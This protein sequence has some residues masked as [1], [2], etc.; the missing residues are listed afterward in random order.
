MEKIRVN[1]WAKLNLSL[2]L[3]PKKGDRGYF[4][5]KFINTQ[6]TLHDSVILCKTKAPGIKLNIYNEEEA[7]E[8]KKNLAFKAAFL[9]MQTFNLPGGIQISIK[10]NIPIRAGLGGG[11]ADAGAVINGLGKLFSIQIS[12]KDKS[13][14]AGRLGMDV[15]YCV[16]GGLCRVEGIGE[17]VEPIPFKLPDLHILIATPIV[18]KP[19]T[20]W[21]Y[22]LIEKK[23]IGKNIEKYNKLIEAIKEE[24]ARAIAENLHNDFEIHVG[25]YFPVIHDLKKIMLR[26][27]AWGAQLAGSGLS[28]FGIFPDDT[29][30]QNA[31]SIL[32]KQ[33]I[34]CI[35][36]KPVNFPS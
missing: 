11:S 3:L 24:N 20:A 23:K 16:T 10:K 9:M 5:V 21:A 27:G 4:K 14:L 8:N 15:F 28:V 22:S 13:S 29:M 12:Q 1:A 25:A 17:M 31:S 30:L 19:G 34:H 7:E 26:S 6:V 18:R 32:K 35:K 2:N 36:V 33:N